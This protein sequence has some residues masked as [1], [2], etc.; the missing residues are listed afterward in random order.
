MEIKDLIDAVQSGDAQDSNN[1]F[2]K[3][4]SSKINS[5]LDAHKRDIAGQMYGTTDTEQ[6][7]DEN[8]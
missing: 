8:V 1:A 3:L 5:K 6:K 7:A 2:N 4:M